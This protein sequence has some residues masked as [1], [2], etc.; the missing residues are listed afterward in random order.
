VFGQNFLQLKQCW[1]GEMGGGRGV[2]MQFVPGRNFN[3]SRMPGYGFW[4][5]TI[6]A[7]E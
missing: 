6:V 1:Q 2:F 3:L 4:P 7:Y 5:G